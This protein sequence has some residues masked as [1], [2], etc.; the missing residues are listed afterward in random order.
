MK[1]NP[2]WYSMHDSKI[3]H[4]KTS[5]PKEKYVSSNY[6]FEY[7]TDDL[8]TDV[9]EIVYQKC[10][11][12]I[13][14]PL[15]KNS[16][17]GDPCFM[18]EKFVFVKDKVY[19]ENEIIELNYQENLEIYYGIKFQKINVTQIVLNQ[20]I[21]EIYI[22]ENK[23]ELFGD[24][25]PG[26]FKKLWIYD[27]FNKIRVMD[28]ANV[29]RLPF[30]EQPKKYCFIHSCHLEKSGTKKLEN[31]VTR[32]KN[33]KLL[34]KTEYVYI[35]N[36][37]L[38]IQ[39]TFGSKFIVNNYSENP[40]LYEIPT[41]NKILE[42]SKNNP[43]SY[44]LYLHTKGIRYVDDYVEENDWIDMMTYFLIDHNKNCF[45]KLDEGYETTGCNF[46]HYRHHFSG[47]F[48]WAKSDYLSKLDPLDEINP[49]KNEAEFWLFFKSPK[50]YCL[51]SSNIN[52]YKT[53]YPKEL[54][55]CNQFFIQYG[56]DEKRIDVTEI[57]YKECFQLEIPLHKNQL[58][59]DPCF[60]VE[61]FLFVNDEKFP[62]N[63][64]VFVEN[65]ENLEIFYGT[66]D[67]K[68]NVTEKCK[69]KCASLILIPKQKNE[70]FGDPLPGIEKNIYIQDS[71]GNKYQ[72]E[73]HDSIIIDVKQNKVYLDHLT[74]LSFFESKRFSCSNLLQLGTSNKQWKEYF[75]RADI[76]QLDSNFEEICLTLEKKTF[77]VIVC[78]VNCLKTIYYLTENSALFLKS[79]GWLIFENLEN[80]EKVASFISSQCTFIEHE[81]CFIIQKIED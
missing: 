34:D 79:N 21:V 81:N 76:E 80:V 60:G 50:F 19:K 73:E 22:P 5:Y 43:N 66:V 53:R 58:F 65:Q 56:N 4:Y 70:L 57:V 75:I 69:E 68:I 9:T 8:K 29:F 49:I 40:L 3:D 59:G 6:V 67:C 44:I 62:E 78:S 15:D 12:K 77:D 11:T 45:T 41:L 35:N 26:H 63:K 16:L 54:Y 28:E 47:N 72:Y 27:D 55:I 71:F 14:I 31:L 23:N 25:V 7:G 64:I 51:H 18:V 36:I 1:Q 33:S 48:W 46:V 13:I 24:P 10:W 39:N 30:I 20:C 38:P 42:F 37:G 61:K 52:H 17:F 74:S 32:I 2:N